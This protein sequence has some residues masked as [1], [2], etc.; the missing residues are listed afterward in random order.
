MTM[1]I[2]H[3]RTLTQQELT[4]AHCNIWHEENCFKSNYVITGRPMVRKRWPGS[5][6]DLWCWPGSIT[7]LCGV[8][9]VITGFWG[10]G[11]PGFKPQGEPPF[12]KVSVMK[13]CKGYYKV[14]DV[15][16]NIFPHFF[17]NPLWFWY[18]KLDSH[19]FLDF[20]WWNSVRTVNI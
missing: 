4:K 11:G 12:L 13:L 14:P 10:A 9:W 18:Q 2:L 8:L 6:T 17:S 3:I 20:F 16:H 7:D 15:I 5:I 1:A 19:I